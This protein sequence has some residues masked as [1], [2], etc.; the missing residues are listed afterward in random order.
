MP[1]K[2]TRLLVRLARRF[3]TR[4]PRLL[5]PRAS[6]RVASAEQREK[7]TEEGKQPEQ[8]RSCPGLH[9]AALHAPGARLPNP[10][11]AAPPGSRDC[12]VAPP[13]S[14]KRAKPARQAPAGRSMRRR[15]GNFRSAEPRG[16]RPK[17]LRRKWL[18]C[19]T[20]GEVAMVWGAD[21]DQS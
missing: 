10:V 19:G 17:A 13:S 8:D 5:S 1:G 4:A 18:F 7:A 3:Q 2:L 20:P 15:S 14:R 9:S 16:P 11:A 6:H 21:P 12:V